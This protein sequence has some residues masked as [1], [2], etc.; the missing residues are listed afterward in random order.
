MTR[1]LRSSV[2]PRA[3]SPPSPFLGYNVPAPID[4]GP[5]QR[6]PPPNPTAAPTSPAV[7]SLHR[8]CTYASAVIHPLLLYVPFPIAADLSLVPPAFPRRRRLS[9]TAARLHIQSSHRC[10]PAPRP[11]IKRGRHD[12]ER[13]V[14][15]G[16]DS[17]AHET[18]GSCGGASDV[19]SGHNIGVDS[20]QS[21]ARAMSPEQQA[22]RRTD[23][24]PASLEWQLAAVSLSVLSALQDVIPMHRFVLGRAQGVCASSSLLERLRVGP[25]R[26][27]RRMTTNKRAGTLGLL[28]VE[29]DATRLAMEQLVHQ[30]ELFC[31]TALHQCSEATTR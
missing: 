9:A 30:Q 5:P 8:D 27:T 14:M 29:V 11:G 4:A 20:V 15:D 19:A 31:T 7:A 18:D 17:T 26:G 25:P 2:Q 6:S 24:R 22:G 28:F 13:L 23:E 16:P 21:L 10:Y 3:P 12:E 1:I